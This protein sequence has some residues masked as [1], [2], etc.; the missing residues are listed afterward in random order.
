[1]VA[2]G[3]KGKYDQ[4]WLRLQAMLLPQIDQFMADP[5]RIVSKVVSK[6]GLEV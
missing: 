6:V 5:E 1:M 2:G 4:L 3:R